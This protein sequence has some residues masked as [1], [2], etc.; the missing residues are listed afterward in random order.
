[1]NKILRIEAICKP[2]G[3]CLKIFLSKES[4]KGIM[5]F[6]ILFLSN[7]GMNENNNFIRKYLINN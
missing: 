2:T 6:C 4:H 5:N 7:K 3:K 1:M